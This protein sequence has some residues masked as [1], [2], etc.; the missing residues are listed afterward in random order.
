MLLLAPLRAALRSRT[1]LIAENLLLR[2]QVAVLT[3]STRRRPRLRTRDKL[4]WV[5]ARRGWRGWRRHP[6]LVRP[7]TVLRWHRQG[8]RLFRRWRSRS[9]LGRP[10]L[11]PKVRELIARM[12]QEN[13]LWGSERARGELRKLG[14]TANNRSIRRYRC[15]ARRDRR[16]RPGVR[17]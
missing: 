14:I 12:P 2:H 16:A 6:V 13:P 15:A 9:P 4:L 17:S 10:R 11:S 8:W 3:R 7:E 5:L 1:A